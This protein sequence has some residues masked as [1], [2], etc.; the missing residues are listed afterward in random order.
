MK[1]V[2]LVCLLLVT[3]CQVPPTFSAPSETPTPAPVVTVLA[4]VTAQ[5][6]GCQ[7]HGAL[8]DPGCTPGALLPVG[9]DQICVSGYSRGVRNVT[10]AEKDQVY[11]EYG[12]ASHAAYEFEIDHLS[13]LELGGSNAIANL[14]PQVRDSEAPGG[15]GFE[16][17]DKTENAAHDAVCSGNLA[18]GDAQRQIETNWVALCA[19]LNVDPKCQSATPAAEGSP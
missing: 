9:A 19:S 15:L 10:Q 3:A 8:P 7:V 13:S 14:W 5:S 11:A 6:A 18:L 1:V 16:T 2:L 17:K 12:I 4:T